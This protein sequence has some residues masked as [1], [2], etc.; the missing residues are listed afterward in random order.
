[1]YASPFPASPGDAQ[2]VFKGGAVL[3]TLSP[4]EGGKEAHPY[5]RHAVR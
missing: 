3:H 4:E 2:L 1:M 5:F